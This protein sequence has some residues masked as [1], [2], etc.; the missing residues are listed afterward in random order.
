VREL[1]NAVEG[2]CVLAAGEVV[3]L[4]DFSPDASRAR[5]GAPARAPAPAPRRA[6]GRTQPPPAG[7]PAVSI[8]VSCTLAEAERRFVLANLRHHRTRARTARALGIGLRTLYTKLAAWG[9]DEDAETA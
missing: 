9:R 2:A 3:T 5:G 8:P 6:R 1:R 4:E 7:A